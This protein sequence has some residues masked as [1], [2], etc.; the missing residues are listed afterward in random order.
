M[1]GR[2]ASGA[3]ET[4]KGLPLG[5]KREAA[6]LGQYYQ[7]AESPFSDLYPQVCDHDFVSP[8]QDLTGTPSRAKTISKYKNLLVL[9]GAQQQ[10]TQLSGAHIQGV[11]VAVR[12]IGSRHWYFSRDF[13]GI[14][15]KR[16]LELVQD[17]VLVTKATSS[18]TQ[19]AKKISINE[20]T[21]NL[22]KFTRPRRGDRH[23]CK[24][25]MHTNVQRKTLV[26]TH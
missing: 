22:E 16:L 11:G 19:E 24:A 8:F 12:E 14:P 21:E 25:F 1:G 4:P 3:G 5:E 26:R 20:L 7:K 6:S 13:P 15:L 23:F 10:Q 9:P 18:K 2:R 17:S